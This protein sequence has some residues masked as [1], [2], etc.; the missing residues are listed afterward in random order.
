M[1]HPIFFSFA[2]D[3]TSL[4]QKIKRRFSDDLVYIY[5]RTGANGEDFPEEI[6]GELSQCKIFV[7][8]WSA[9]YI[10]DDKERPW[11]RRE[12]LTALRR[13]EAGN[14]KNY[15]LV[16]V[17]DT[18]LE[19]HFVDPETGMMS[20]FL[21]PL[22]EVKRAFT[23]PVDHKAVEHRLAGEL[24]QLLDGGMPV[25]PRTV[26]Q[27]ELRSALETGNFETKTPLI[28]VSGFH[29]SGRKTLI[30]SI[31]GYE[32]RHLTPF[33]LPIEN[34]DGPE[35]VLRLIW[36]EVLHKTAGEQRQM[37]ENIASSPL[38]LA[39][40][41]K[42]L[43]TQLTSRNAY[44]ILTKEELIDFGES[45]PS[46]VGQFFGLLNP[47]VQP[48]F[49]FTIPRPLP[50]QGKK[51]IPNFGEVSLPS[52]EDDESLR[53]VNMVI[54]ACDPSRIGRWRTHIP[55]ILDSASNSPKMIVD[56][57]RLA[58]RRASLD[59]LKQNSEVEV[60]RFDQRVVQLLKWAW[61]QI[62]HREEK[63]LLLD[64]L[65]SLGVAHYDALEDIFKGELEFGDELYE[66]V[67]LGMVEQLT[68][69]TYRIPPALRRKLNFYLINP[70]LKK[71][72][73]SLLRRYARD[74]NIGQDSHGAIKLTNNI[75]TKLSVDVEVSSADLAFVTAAMLFKA[76][77]ERYRRHQHGAA[78]TLFRRAFEKR[79]KIH[80]EAT[81]VE[82]ARFYGLA[83][84]RESV[85][86]DMNTACAYLSNA[87]NFSTRIQN[88]AR[89]AALFIQ[90]FSA[91]LS[92]DFIRACG[93]FE[94][95]LAILPAHAWA[96]HQRSQI[97]N[98]LV[99]CI[100]KL[101]APD[102]SRAV[103][104][105]QMLC[106][107]RETPNNLDVLLRALL[108]Q[109]YWDRQISAGQRQNN[110]AEIHRRE[111]QLKEKCEGSNL[112]FYIFRLVDRL[113]VERL[114]DVTVNGLGYGSLDL[115]EPIKICADGYIKLQEE[116]L[117]CRKWDLLL[118][119]EKNRDWNSL[120]NEVTAY[121]DSG[122]LDRRGQGIAARIRVLTFDL[123]IHANKIRARTELNKYKASKIIPQ[124]I[125]NDIARKIEIVNF[126]QYRM[127]YST[128]GDLEQ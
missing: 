79:D 54:G 72:T 24:A 116:A 95:S 109:T 18:A 120:H 98:E 75:Q 39:R 19:A 32:Y 65:N 53:L 101:H 63:M 36:G 124:S 64:I 8:F 11:C 104:L 59:F 123:S 121:L 37:M 51:L 58:N 93:F 68:E 86:L 85:G 112:S 60:E 125:A 40:Y 77:W 117:I 5:T 41:Y 97:L 22:R 56:I 2:S 74:I 92:R 23:V 78:L 28:F 31:M 87:S 76:G 49:F 15:F 25:L 12:L 6:L 17:D 48:L 20:D 52:L 108:A 94:E 33:V 29:G 61:E 128:G 105:A 16:Q 100:L 122:T 99:Q 50:Y 81:R 88:K 96:D 118:H 13:I 80:D 30:Q 115:S 45:V 114:E 7:V 44:V 55:F 21:K 42:Q 106:T 89:A 67:Q 46:W 83:S 1:T 113:E 34:S 103:D 107:V 3:S 14:L 73:H 69:S 9:K 102:Y 84:A 90:G 35:D 66:L 26:Y 91:R 126:G 111:Q 27:D 82:L 70:E 38:A 57:V 119:D 110:F 47:C 127:L 10:A 62:R 43:S 4:A 71:K